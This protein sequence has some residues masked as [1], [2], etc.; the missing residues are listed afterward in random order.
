[1][2]DFIVFCICI[3]HYKQTNG[4]IGSTKPPQLLSTIVCF[5]M[6]VPEKY[7]QLLQKKEEQVFGLKDSLRFPSL[8]Y[9]QGV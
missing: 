9:S 2:V 4:H 6:K 8:M 1:M 3:S 7:Q 5:N